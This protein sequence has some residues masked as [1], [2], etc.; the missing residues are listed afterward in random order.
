[1]SE[2]DEKGLF[3]PGNKIWEASA[4]FGAPRKFET[5]NQLWE[6]CR[7]Y[8]D[9]CE[10][11]PL[12]EDHVIAF[13]GHAKHEPVAK[14]RAATNAGLCVFLGIN[15]T[16]WQNWRNDREDLKDVIDYVD[17]IIEDRNVTGA[18]AGSLNATLI[19]RLVGLADKQE[20]TGKDG[21]PIKTEEL[22][23]DAA[24]FSSRMARL[25]ASAVESGDSE[26]DT[27]CESGA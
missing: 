27:G 23:S 26:A 19:A 3:L 18:A 6:K 25:S 11:N 13:Q 10:D 16:T 5:P 20:L 17:A 12:Y 9:F 21:G 14:M 22:N 1:M 4:P 15:R 8:F 24:S 7:E 2:R